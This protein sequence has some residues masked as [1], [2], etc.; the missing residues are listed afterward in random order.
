MKTTQLFNAAKIFSL[1]LALFFTA[2]SEA[3]DPMPTD[4]NASDT[5]TTGT[6]GLP[7]TGGGL[8]GGGTG[9]GTGGNGGGSGPLGGGGQPTTNN[10]IGML[11][12][13]GSTYNYTGLTPEAEA[14][15]NDQGAYP[16]YLGYYDDASAADGEFALFDAGNT[17]LFVYNATQAG[18]ITPGTYQYGNAPFSGFFFGIQG[19]GYL[20]A[21]GS[22]SVE[23]TQTNG[24]LLVTISGNVVQV[25]QIA[26][27]L[28]KVSEELIPIE[29]QFAA[30]AQTQAS[31]NGRHAGLTIPTEAI[32]IALAK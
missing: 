32:S 10:V 1:A 13:G 8:P 15:P 24:Q 3:E 20:L 23:T 12:A 28:N 31:T 4:P 6:P 21:D 17:A 14:Q 19:Y 5:T 22:I 26:G 27:E 11:S 9:G 7:G 18:T 16:I 2:C 25:E 29:A 30:P